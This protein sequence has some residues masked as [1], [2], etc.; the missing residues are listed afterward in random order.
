MIRTQAVDCCFPESSVIH[1]ILI[2]VKDRFLG[3]A[4]NRQCRPV[5][6]QCCKLKS[7]II[8]SDDN[9]EAIDDNQ[10]KGCIDGLA[11]FTTVLTTINVLESHQKIQQDL[12]VCRA[13]FVM[14]QLLSHDGSE[15]ADFS[16]RGFIYSVEVG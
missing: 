8:S 7:I 9:G 4:I 5:L 2:K 12:E 11:V 10:T 15:T 1:T 14:G 3:V 6:D 16:E 13:R